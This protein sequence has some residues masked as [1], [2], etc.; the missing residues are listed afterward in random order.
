MANPILAI[1]QMFLKVV[2]LSSFCGLSSMHDFK[3]Q[4]WCFLFGSYRGENS[5]YFEEPLTQPKNTNELT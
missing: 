4:L 5:Q 3:L 2:I 1:L